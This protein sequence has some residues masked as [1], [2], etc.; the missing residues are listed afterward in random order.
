MLKLCTMGWDE[1]ANEGE[2]AP[3]LDVEI[4][5]KRSPWFRFW[6]R[7]Y[8]K[9][10]LVL[11]NSANNEVASW[12]LAGVFTPTH[13]NLFVFNKDSAGELNSN[14]TGDVVPIVQK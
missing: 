8:V 10:S 4:Y 3:L 13:G 14:S 7:P 2:K 6:G 11:V 1:S 9:I 5:F 12:S